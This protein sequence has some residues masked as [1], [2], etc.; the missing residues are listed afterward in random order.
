MPDGDKIHPVIRGYFRRPYR[1]LCEGKATDAEC[2]VVLQDAMKRDLQRVGD[3]A[4]A[5]ALAA[6]DAVAREASSAGGFDPARANAAVDGALREVRC[7]SRYAEQVRRAAR[8]LVQDL[9]Y[10]NRGEIGDA[11]A[12][13]FRRFALARVEAQFTARVPQ[14]PA[15]HNGASPVELDHRIHAIQAGVE[16]AAS[17]FARQVRRTGSVGALRRPARPRPRPVSLSEN[18]L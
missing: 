3:A 7:S 4:A 14:T 16:H 6:G 8:D 18:L 10:G 5:A 9:R 13:V 17:L 11:G 15:H 1:H 2:S 12:D